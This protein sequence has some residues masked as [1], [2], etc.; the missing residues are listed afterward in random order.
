MQKLIPAM[1]V[2][3]VCGL[4]QAEIVHWSQL[5]GTQDADRQAPRWGGLTID[6]SGLSSNDFLGDPDNHVLSV[7]YGAG[8]SITTI[9]W[10]VNLTTVGISWADEAT[11]TFNNTFSVSPGA[12]DAFTVS[13][14][15]YQGSASSSLVLGG[16]GLV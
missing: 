16:D 7:F 10:N 9:G 2:M 4:A 15:N 8:A 1:G 14:M 5:I 13:N 6:I 12:G 3:A 11:I